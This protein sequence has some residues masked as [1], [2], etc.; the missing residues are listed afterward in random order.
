MGLLRIFFLILLGFL[1]YQI[2]K[3]MLKRPEH[4]AHVKGKGSERGDRN[5]KRDRNV[6]DADF[7][8]L[9]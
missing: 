8:E 4:N 2:I 3:P 9:E 5:G 6:E 1:I 7:E